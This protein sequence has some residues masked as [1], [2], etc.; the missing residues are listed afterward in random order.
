MFMFSPNLVLYRGKSPILATAIFVSSIS[1]GVSIVADHFQDAM[2]KLN[3]EGLPLR[4]DTGVVKKF[5]SAIGRE[6][7]LVRSEIKKKV[8]V[9]ARSES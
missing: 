9:R 3:I 6:S 8:S 5:I 1:L 2:R 4:R 7:T